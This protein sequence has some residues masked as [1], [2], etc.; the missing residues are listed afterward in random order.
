MV[1]KTKSSHCDMPTFGLTIE[2]E[3]ILVIYSWPE[4]ELCC[5]QIQYCQYLC[6]KYLGPR[7][8]DNVS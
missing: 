5:H 7:Y 2:E 4:N 3:G 1:A 8:P 6:L